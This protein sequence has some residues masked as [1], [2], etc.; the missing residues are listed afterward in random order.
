MVTFGSAPPPITIYEGPTGRQKL[1][2]SVTAL[3]T[4]PDSHKLSLVPK[5]FG[6]GRE[7]DSLGNVS[8][9]DRIRTC[10]FM[11]PNHAL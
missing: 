2:G 5:P 1:S 3:V 9:G 11:V 10:D 7:G 6:P 4:E 8:R